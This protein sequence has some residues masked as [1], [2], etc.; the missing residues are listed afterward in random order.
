[1]GSE[2]DGLAKCFACFDVKKEDAEL[3][4]GHKGIGACR[5]WKGT[6]AV[7][8]NDANFFG[9]V[10]ATGGSG[11]KFLEKSKND[12]DTDSGYLGLTSSMSANRFVSEPLD[13]NSNSHR[14]LGI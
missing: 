6:P 5:Y 10:E 3:E 13:V 12:W 14:N 9:T 7:E 1:M 11:F 2:T 4:E 8:Y